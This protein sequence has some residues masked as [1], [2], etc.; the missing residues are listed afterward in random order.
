VAYSPDDATVDALFAGAAVSSDD[1]AAAKTLSGA[2]A[3]V[4]PQGH[5]RSTDAAP[6]GRPTRAAASELSLD[7]VFREPPQRPSGGRERGEFSFDQFFSSESEA[8][9]SDDAAEKEE[10]RG[11]DDITQF[12]S[13][14]EGLKKK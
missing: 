12:N 4:A 10:P 9:A 6:G 7:H 8:I 11:S 5:E 3:A 1:E 14:L 13:W 2:F